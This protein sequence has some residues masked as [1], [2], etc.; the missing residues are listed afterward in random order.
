MKDIIISI[1]A[2]I[3]EIE[4]VNQSELKAALLKALSSYAEEQ[5]KNEMQN[6]CGG[7]NEGP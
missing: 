3:K 7:Y 2:E 5:G 4:S 6:R 1:G